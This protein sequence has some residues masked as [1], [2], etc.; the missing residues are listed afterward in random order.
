[1][2][3]PLEKFLKECHHFQ[4]VDALKDIE[5]RVSVLHGRKFALKGHDSQITYDKL[6][7]II[8]EKS[9][10]YHFG[11]SGGQELKALLV[12]IDVKGEKELKKHPL[13]RFFTL[14]KRLFIRRVRKQEL[15][16]I[17]QMEERGLPRIGL[18]YN[19]VKV[20]RNRS[21]FEEITAYGNKHKG[22]VLAALAHVG[23][24]VTASDIY[25]GE[26]SICVKCSPEP[27][28][29]INSGK[30]KRDVFVSPQVEL[31][32]DLGTAAHFK[33]MLTQLKQTAPLWREMR[34]AMK[35]LYLEDRF[36]QSIIDTDIWQKNLA[37]INAK[38]ELREVQTAFRFKIVDQ[39]KIEVHVTWE[40]VIWK[41]S[42]SPL[43]MTIET[44]EIFPKADADPYA[45][46]WEGWNKELE[47]KVEHHLWAY[48]VIQRE[49]QEIPG[50]FNLFGAPKPDINKPL[51][52]LEEMMKLAPGTLTDLADAKNDVE[53]E[54]QLKKIKKEGGL[55][56]HPDK[57]GTEAQ[58]QEFDEA[59]K[60]ALELLKT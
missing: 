51:Q 37:K 14:L 15:D 8:K 27:Y 44:K 49:G 58:F 25:F 10:G 7:H 20:L 48:L 2:I 33:Q 52:K 55:Q 32:F 9:A 39:D 26:G 56:F 4:L 11:T 36:K 22:E 28:C 5:C 41:N 53:L 59:L 30:D 16:I 12:D 17:T 46:F 40:V 57:G 42:G 35:P 54:K 38:I 31:N 3:N 13:A 45:S 60:Q 50:L 21:R 43:N 47:K 29:N 23:W 6:V 24:H 34:E 1:M 18:V 19:G